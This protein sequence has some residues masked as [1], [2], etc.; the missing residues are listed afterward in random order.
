M[1]SS[2]YHRKQAEILAGLALAAPDEVMSARLSLLA[3]EHHALAGKRD[4]GQSR[5]MPPPSRG[6]DSRDRV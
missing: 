6:D 1:A 2:E 3:L 5:S 4:P